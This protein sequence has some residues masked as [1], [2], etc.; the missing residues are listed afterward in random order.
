MSEPTR[1]P[2]VVSDQPSYWCKKLRWKSYTLDRDNASAAAHLFARGG[3]SFSC[4]STVSAFGEDDGPVAPERC[5]PA[6][7]CYEEHPTLVM[8]RR[9]V[10]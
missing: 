10:S 8:L 5:H 6:R 9:A 7:P 4:L 3:Q 2:I 1:T